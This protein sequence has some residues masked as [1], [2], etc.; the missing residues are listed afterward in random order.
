MAWFID[1]NDGIECTI[2]DSQDYDELTETY[3]MVCVGVTPDDAKTIVQ[4][5][6]AHIREEE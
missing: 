4:L 5:F 2:Y 1:N 3:G 6:N